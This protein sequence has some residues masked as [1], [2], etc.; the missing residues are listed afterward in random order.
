MTRRLLYVLSILGVLLVGIV[1]G[2]RTGFRAATYA[3]SII[4]ETARQDR[5]AREA[6]I[7]A[8][9]NE[10]LEYREML[11]FT[12]VASWYGDREH[13]RITANRTRFD[14][15]A[16]TAAS[17]FMRF[18]SWWIVRNLANG[19]QTEVRITDDGPNVE[20]RMVDLSEA[21]ARELG[22]ERVGKARVMMTPKIGG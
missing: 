4:I 20:G 22:M 13:G 11:S 1:A 15:F 5:D 19:K 8:Q 2:Y 3:D 18:G 17:K 10:I 6:F 14:R 16:L 12:G 7:A 9:A 21:A